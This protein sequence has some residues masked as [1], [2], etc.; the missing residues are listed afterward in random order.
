M[1]G[2][3][4]VAGRRNSPT[5]V[6]LVSNGHSRQIRTSGYRRSARHVMPRLSRVGTSETEEV[7]SWRTQPCSRTCAGV[8][9]NQVRRRARGTTKAW[10]KLDQALA[11]LLKKSLVVRRS[12]A[13]GC[14]LVV[15][16]E[17]H[18]DHDDDEKKDAPGVLRHRR[19]S[20]STS[21]AL[22]HSRL[23]SMPVATLTSD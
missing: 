9:P 11:G 15:Q 7:I 22:F 12:A 5:G 20:I 6:E 3:G 17:K 10:P 14:H 13:N 19:P 23:T 8:K 21:L 18:N 16:A 4:E 2:P 1:P